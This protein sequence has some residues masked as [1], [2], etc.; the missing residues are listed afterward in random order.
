MIP[1]LC[2]VQLRQVCE[3]QSAPLP[4]GADQLSCSRCETVLLPGVNCK[5]LSGRPKK[6]PDSRAVLYQ[7][8]VCTHAGAFPGASRAAERSARAEEAAREQIERLASESGPKA[9]EVLEGGPKRKRAR[10]KVQSLKALAKEAVKQREELLGPVSVNGTEPKPLIKPEVAKNVNPA[11]ETI[12]DEVIPAVTSAVTSGTTDTNMTAGTVLS[13]S[14][15]HSAEAGKTISGTEP[16]PA[17]ESAEAPLARVGPETEPKK[18]TADVSFEDRQP[19]LYSSL[20]EAT[21]AQNRTETPPLEVPLPEK[22]APLVPPENTES[23]AKPGVF[24]PAEKAT[25]QRTKRPGRGR[26]VLGAS[27][28]AKAGQGERAAPTSAI[29]GGGDDETEESPY[30]KVSLQ[31]EVAEGK[32]QQEGL[33][34][35]QPPG[36]G[37]G[38]SEREAAVMRGTA[39]G[40]E[41]NRGAEKEA[42]EGASQAAAEAGE[43]GRKEVPTSKASLKP[44]VAPASELPA[45][46]PSTQH[47]PPPS[48]PES[49][50]D[51]SLRRSARK[52]GAP[53][54]SGADTATSSKGAETPSRRSLRNGG[55]G[56][57]EATT[58]LRRSTRRAG[59]VEPDAKKAAATPGR[60]SGRTGGV[61]DAGAEPPIPKPSR[62]AGSRSVS[63]EPD[64]APQTTA[65][66]QE[67]SAAAEQQKQGGGRNL[68]S[69]LGP[70]AE[71]LEAPLSAFGPSDPSGG[72]ASALEVSTQETFV[73]ATQESVAP[74]GEFQSQTNSPM[75]EMETQPV[76]TQEATLGL[77]NP[78]P[79]EQ[80][81][82]PL[83][84]ETSPTEREIVPILA[85]GATVIGGVIP[86]TALAEE[87]TGRGVA[88]E[89]AVTGKEEGTKGDETMANAP[90]THEGEEKD[91]GREEGNTEAVDLGGAL[92]TA[93]EVA[94]E[95]TGGDVRMGDEQE[96][97]S[98]QRDTLLEP[99]VIAPAKK[100]RRGSPEAEKSTPPEREGA[101]VVERENDV[102]PM[103]DDLSADVRG[104]LGVEAGGLS[105]P[106]LGIPAADELLVGQNGATANG[107]ESIPRLAS[108]E[109]ADVRVASADVR[110]PPADV[111]ASRPASA[112]LP[113]Q[114]IVIEDALALADGLLTSPTLGLG[115][116]G[117][118]PPTP[119]P[120]GPWKTIAAAGEPLDDV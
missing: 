18:P 13:K 58:P 77:D 37:E 96:P 71:L 49:S 118:F 100:R 57:A 46:E 72:V 28:A 94:E 82:A 116:E 120:E 69:V 39:V 17:L 56:L 106:D 117:H 108:A 113:P 87:G 73:T 99:D 35:E 61:G 52:R 115:I 92:R 91:E 114:A 98:E 2:S 109:S 64:E 62:R 105:A 60:R 88:E 1:S 24:S 19:A 110:A 111:A 8:L 81:E 3:S 25:P 107:A 47:P 84:Q 32:S 34:G 103:V 12:L 79:P 59:S 9:D 85:E 44:P 40:D 14:D 119:T 29:Q 26:S 90:D 54:G 38:D 48:E 102:S 30:S 23:S 78:T 21:T 20:G 7:C 95:I 55:A 97:E 16:L 41:S 5:V 70:I 11:Q 86:E 74:G 45:D 42:K 10:G 6:H 33:N 31:K 43:G 83:A 65:V 80:D 27:M 93:E 112:R 63:A 75:E 4:K 51:T 53:N 101:P 68:E 15:D 66:G 104:S 50:V 76:P 67:E 89:G 36:K 22:P